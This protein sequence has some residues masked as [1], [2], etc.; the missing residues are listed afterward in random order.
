MRRKKLSLPSR[1]GAQVVEQPKAESDKDAATDPLDNKS[2]HNRGCKDATSIDY[3]RRIA[4][5]QCEDLEQ[6]R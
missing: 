3:C 5:T 2:T 4:D 6:W 1:R